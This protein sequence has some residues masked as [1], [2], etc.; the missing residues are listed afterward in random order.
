MRIKIKKPRKQV[1]A[2]NK[3]LGRK[4]EY[5]PQLPVDM[6]LYIK[7]NHPEANSL[8][9]R[10]LQRLQEKVGNRVVQKLV[11]NQHVSENSTLPAPIQR[12]KKGWRGDWPR[13]KVAGRPSAKAKRDLKRVR[14]FHSQ[15]HASMSSS[16]RKGF[17]LKVL[18]GMSR[19]ELVDFDWLYKRE[20][21]IDLKAE[22]EALIRSASLDAEIKKEFPEIW[23]P[24]TGGL[25]REQRQEGISI[26]LKLKGKW[27]KFW[28]AP[29]ILANW[30]FNEK[31]WGKISGSFGGGVGYSK[32]YIGGGETDWLFTP[33]TPDQVTNWKTGGAVDHLRAIALKIDKQLYQFSKDIGWLKYES[34][35]RQAGIQIVVGLKTKIRKYQKDWEILG[36]ETGTM[37]QIKNMLP[38]DF[39]KFLWSEEERKKLRLWNTAT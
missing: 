11:L 18:K 30:M 2:P 21:G 33:P 26:G 25:T 8:S 36:K 22:M 10:A 38:G 32:E 7:S 1:A 6:M 4:T 39:M 5:S 19:K 27:P 23:N 37:E 31:V 14:L 28:V 34:G 35:T 13:G 16:V 15:L 17:I 9:F 12:Q 24:L 20:F 29:E 3:L